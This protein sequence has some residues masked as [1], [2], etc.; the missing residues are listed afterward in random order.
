MLVVALAWACVACAQAGGDAARV[1][2]SALVG[3]WRNAAGAGLHLGS[4]RRMNWTHLN[5]AILGGTSCPDTA[6]GH[7]E[8]FGPPDAHGSSFADDALTRGDHVALAIDGSD[9]FCDVSA[10]VRRDGKGLDLCLVEDPDSDCSAEE[11]LRREPGAR[12]GRA[13]Q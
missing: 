13:G 12:K 6:A 8:F 11:L 4:D 2:E 5:R 3:E 1:D 9:S 10:M 7:W